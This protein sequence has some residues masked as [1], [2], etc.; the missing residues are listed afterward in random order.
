MQVLVP[1][2]KAPGFENEC[3]R[4]SLLAQKAPKNPEDLEAF[5]AIA[6]W[7]CLRVKRGGRTKAPGSDQ[8]P[9]I[10]MGWLPR[11]RMSG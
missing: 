11:R 4:Q 9:F 5:T 2:P 8:V 7:G 10:F 3:Q 1:D 6:D